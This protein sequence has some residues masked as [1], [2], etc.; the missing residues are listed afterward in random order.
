[1]KPHDVIARVNGEGVRSLK[2]LEFA[3]END[4]NDDGEVALTLIREGA[5]STH[6]I[7][8]HLHGRP[9]A[10]NQRQGPQP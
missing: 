4:E 3:L 2:H 6:E 9:G 10:R 8:A 5:L 7:V 1:L